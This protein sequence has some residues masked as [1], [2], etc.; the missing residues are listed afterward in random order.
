M[1]SND[2]YNSYYGKPVQS[3]SQKQKSGFYDA[4]DPLGY[5]QWM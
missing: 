5:S 2:K 4:A 1:L 3:S